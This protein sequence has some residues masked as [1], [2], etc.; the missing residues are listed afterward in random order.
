MAFTVRLKAVS[1]F[2]LCSNPDCNFIEERNC[3]SLVV[4][5]VQSNSAGKLLDLLQS[6]H[7]WKE[8]HT[9]VFCA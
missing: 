6:L 2:L 3:K 1:A 5:I 4:A 8:L 9:K 7:I